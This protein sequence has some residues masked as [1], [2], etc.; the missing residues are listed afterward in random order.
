MLID[1]QD[2]A[3]PLRLET[4]GPEQFK[5]LLVVDRWMLEPSLE[6]LVTDYGA[7]L[8]LPK[9]YKLNAAAPALKGARVHYSRLAFRMVGIELPQN[10]RMT[11]NL[12]GISVIERLWD[13][14]IA[15]DSASTGAAQLVYKSYLRTL[16]IPDLRSIVAAGGPAMNGLIQ[17]TDMMRRFQGIEGI[18]LLDAEDE[19]DVQTHSAFSGLSDALNQF[20]QQLSGALQIPLV[21]LFG[22]SP[23]GLN[24]SGESD[25]RTYYDHIRQRQRKDMLVGV[26][27]IY[28]LIAR[29]KGIKL[30]NNFAIDFTSLWQLDDVQKADVAGKTQTAVSGALAD[31]LLTQ[32]GAMKELRQSSRV[33]GI[34]TNITEENINAADD[35]VAP[36]DAGEA[37]PGDPN[38]LGLPPQPG[39]EPGPGLPGQKKPDNLNLPGDKNA[40]VRPQGQAP[41][42]DAGKTRRVQLQQPIAGGGKAGG[43][44][45]KGV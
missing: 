13:R 6:D 37:L 32:Q 35:M 44:A 17:Y 28:K 16:K 40:E 33:T 9:Y 38:T 1:G 27:T 18:T 36:P 24:S 23:A 2:P 25:I 43:G 22:Q 4:V 10:Q 42:L 45:G 11:E 15:F 41:K 3:T 20:G 30:P 21:R 39:G 29:S 14:M 12:W 5:G 34:F 26:T 8:G 31:G 19:F 7:H